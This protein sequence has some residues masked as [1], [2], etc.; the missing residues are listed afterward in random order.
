MHFIYYYFFSFY[1]GVLYNTVKVLTMTD[2]LRQN[3]FLKL[4]QC[5][6][7]VVCVVDEKRCCDCGRNVAILSSKQILY[8]IIH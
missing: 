1:V 3:T 5:V 6:R 4:Y 2:M 7:T 8:L